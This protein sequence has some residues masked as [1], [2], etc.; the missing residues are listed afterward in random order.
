MRVRKSHEDNH[1]I[2]Q[3]LLPIIAISFGLLFIMKA[4]NFA[5]AAS[6]KTDAS[7]AEQAAGKPAQSAANTEV[8]L[9]ASIAETVSRDRKNLNARLIDFEARETALKALEVKL[10]GQIKTIS[11]AKANL[12]EQADMMSREANSDLAHLVTMY[13]TMKPKKAAEI[14]DNMD[15]AFAAGFL[16][17]IDGLKAGLIM[18]EMD[19]KNSYKISVLIA[20]RNAKWRQAN[21]N[22]NEGD[23][24][25]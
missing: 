3:R 17:E 7:K 10:N 20:N 9:T 8:C 2:K 19:T 18:A 23:A 24:A 15:P 4:T 1:M 22:A 25:Q 14:F 5:S 6:E 13:S 16:R 12:Q 21:V 11:E